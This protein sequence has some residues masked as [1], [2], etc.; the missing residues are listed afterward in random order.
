M[1]KMLGKVFLL[2]LVSL[3]IFSSGV[4]AEPVSLQMAED[5]ARTHLRANNER[6]KC[7]ARTVTSSVSSMTFGSSS[8]TGNC[9]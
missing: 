7:L 6:E 4:F 1:D 3:F 5:V 8:G 9:G 2:S